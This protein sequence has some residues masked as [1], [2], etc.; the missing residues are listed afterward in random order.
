MDDPYIQ[1][2]SD[3]SVKNEW[4]TLEVRRSVSHDDPF[5]HAEPLQLFHFELGD[6]DICGARLVQRRV[7]EGRGGV[8]HRA[9]AFV[10]LARLAHASQQLVRNRLV[11][12]VVPR[13][14]LQHHLLRQPVLVQLRRLRKASQD[15]VVV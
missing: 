13:M 3:Y 12:Y 14:S 10:K 11:R 15:A 1:T 2:K 7:H 4:L 5:R 6:I 9:E 8:L